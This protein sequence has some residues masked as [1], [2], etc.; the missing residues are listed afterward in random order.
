L[1]RRLAIFVG[2]FGLDG[3]EAV[4]KMTSA[5]ANGTDT[6]AAIDLLAGLVDKSLLHRV[7]AHGPVPRFAM[8]ET[9]REFAL[10]QI[11]EG[12]EAEALEAVRASHM[13]ALAER[14]DPE[15]MASQQA[16][17]LENLE[18]QLPN[19][20]AA[21]AWFLARGDAEQGLRLASAFTWFWSS[22]GY[23]REA[24]TWLEAFLAMPTT[25]PTRARGLLDA[26][27]IRHWLGDNN[28]AAVDAGESLAIYRD[29]GDRY[30]AA[31][32][33]RRLGS[34]AIDQGEHE[35]SAEQRAESQSLLEPD[36]PVWDFA[37]AAFLGGRLASAGGDHEA[38]IA[39]FAEAA[40]GF[41]AL[42]DRGYVAAALGQQV[43]ACLTIGDVERARAAYAE[44]LALARDVQDLT[45]ISWALAGAAHLAH[46]AG[47]P[48]TAARLL[49][50]ATAIREATGEARLPK[51][52]LDG[53][54]QTALGWPRFSSEWAAGE[55][56]SEAD[57]VAEAQGVL[58]AGGGKPARVLGIHGD[59][60]SLTRRE[61]DVLRLL[62]EGRTDKEIGG[63]LQLSCRTVSNHVGSILTKLGVE[64]RTAAVAVAMRH[65]LL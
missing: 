65:G 26:A 27:N 61:R 29:L 14:A 43:A 46:D 59:S 30:L 7:D 21:L 38:A 24:R 5:T 60:W 63:V 62:G 64:S 23:L 56:R 45:S 36:D 32:A 42:N 51:S 37:F 20:R 35:R 17:W 58:S 55:A 18:A 4:W 31:C 8:L 1:F 10:A 11:T 3:V 28:Q 34:I 53:V 44:S 16:I 33:L 15:M 6:V 52:T 9:I 39:S 50:K 22:R 13:L 40:E 41:R 2:S 57:A 54:L 19:A 48:A 47:E 12:G 25:A 49:A